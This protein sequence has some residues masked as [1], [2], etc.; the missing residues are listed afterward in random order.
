LMPLR[1]LGP[2]S[3]RPPRR[4]LMRLGPPGS[5]GRWS[6]VAD[7]VP[8]A[9]PATERVHA[10]ALALLQRHGVL[11]R[12]AAVGEGLQG[13]F[14]AIYPVL[15]AM[16]ESGKIRRGYFLEGLGG[17]QFAL[18]G[19]VDRLRATR[20]TDRASVALAAPDPARGD[21]RN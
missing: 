21:G 17:S 4:P 3:R 13:G 10:Q 2:R 6:Q 15:R 7:L 5:A 18:A 8:P 20:E 12:E 16:E 9:L 14:A 19:A 11:T 1:V